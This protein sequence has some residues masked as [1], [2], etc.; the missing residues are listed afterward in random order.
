MIQISE[1]LPDPI[2]KDSEGE[3]IELQNNGETNISLVGWKIKTTNKG[4]FYLKGSIGSGELRL[5]KRSETKL[6]LKNDGETI[7]LYD[8]S[9][10][11]TDE[12]SYSFQA[13][14]GKSFARTTNGF[15]STEP[16]PGGQNKVVLAG[17]IEQNNPEGI[18]LN[19]QAGG[20][21][22]GGLGL[23]LFLAL[24]ILFVIKRNEDLQHIFF[25]RNT[26]TGR[27]TSF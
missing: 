24:G 7:Y 18:P 6:T 14:E 27:K 21:W 5:L 23:A 10:A 22:A 11:L 3:W 25:G 16:T 12:A 13:V 20:L 15:V 4:E 8:K 1:F 2:G 26:E 9:G 17:L 19:K